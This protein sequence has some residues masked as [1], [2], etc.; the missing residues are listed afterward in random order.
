MR[1]IHTKHFP[2]GGY[3]SINLF[4]VVFTKKETID[5]IT[6]NHELIHTKQMQEML[7]IFFYIWYVLE[8]LI[9]RLFHKKQNGAYHD[10]SFEEEAYAYEEDFTYIFSRKRKHYAWLKYIKIKSAKSINL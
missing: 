8:Y 3:S 4:G 9:I 5:I 6:Y 2:P 7:Y 1:I 10:V